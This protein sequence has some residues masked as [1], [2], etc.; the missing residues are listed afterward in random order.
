MPVGRQKEKQ[1]NKQK[2]ENAAAYPAWL[3]LLARFLERNRILPRGR[4]V[5]PP[6]E[7]DDKRLQ[8]RGPFPSHRRRNVALMPLLFLFL[9]F[10]SNHTGTPAARQSRATILRR[11][12]DTVWQ[13]FRLRVARPD[14]S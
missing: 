3:A 10:F 8:N 14:P 13:V 2:Q 12:C 5:A 4:H 7:T 9:F 1:R 11:C 6:M